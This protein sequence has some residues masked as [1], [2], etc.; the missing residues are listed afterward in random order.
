MQSIALDE[1]EKLTEAAKL[2]PNPNEAMPSKCPAPPPCECAACAATG[3]GDGGGGTKPAAATSGGRQLYQHF[4]KGKASGDGWGGIPFVGNEHPYSFGG[5]GVKGATLLGTDASIATGSAASCKYLDIMFQHAGRQRC[6]LVVDQE[7]G[8][9]HAE[10]PCSRPHCHKQDGEGFTPPFTVSYIMDHTGEESKPARIEIPREKILRWLPE[11]RD[12]NLLPFLNSKKATEKAAEALI[13]RG[14]GDK[15][16]P[17]TLLVM[18]ANAGHMGLLLN[19]FC[20]L[21]AAGI[22][23]PKH[24]VV[25]PTAALRDTLTAAGIT[26]FF[27]EGL[28]AF[29]DKP[30]QVCNH[31][32]CNAI[33]LVPSSVCVVRCA[34]LQSA[35]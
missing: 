15:V 26:A 27:H 5:A 31:H 30:S 35:S 8:W 23:T 18:T 28:G 34:V 19:F 12:K 7:Y 11:V 17:E 24:F 1:L 2:K 22:A 20:S 4:I 32:H 3:V 13:G 29:T 10:T 16:A 25:A 33:M 14:D 21:K 6:T 9:K